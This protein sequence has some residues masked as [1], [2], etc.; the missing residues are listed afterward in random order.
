MGELLMDYAKHREG[1]AWKRYEQGFD[2]KL[3][4][5]AVAN[6]PLNGLIT[7]KHL[8]LLG[9][10]LALCGSPSEVFKLDFLDTATHA[11]KEFLVQFV[12]QF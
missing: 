1:V 5:E 2:R 6:Y 12:R 11:E 4:D 8:A 10:A 9:A 3:W 7:S